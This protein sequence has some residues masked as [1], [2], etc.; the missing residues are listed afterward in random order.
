MKDFAIKKLYYSISEV[1]KMT[2][3]KPYV[4]RYWEG[5]FSEL[6]PSKNRAGK[7]IYRSSDIDI[8]LLIKKLLYTDKFTIE[9]AKRKLKEISRGE[10]QAAQAG[11]EIQEPSPDKK[12]DG[13]VSEIRQ[14]LHDI[15]RIIDG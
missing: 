1:S 7:R 3:V 10:Q 4:L 8:V 2:S 6:R 15:I 12:K 9:G 13:L 11:E 14:G 5:E